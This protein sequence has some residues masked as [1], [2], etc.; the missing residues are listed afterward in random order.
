MS[1]LNESDQELLDGILNKD[2]NDLTENDK[3]ILR[4]RSSYLTGDQKENYKSILN[5]KQKDG[6]LP[7][8]DDGGKEETPQSK[9]NDILAGRSVEDV[10]TKQLNKLAVIYGIPE[11]SKKNRETLIQAIKTK[12][13]PAGDE[14]PE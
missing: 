2:K 1:K 4:A 8:D 6:G 3:A 9:A 13:G 10:P 12:V 7:T 5:A 11:E 14:K